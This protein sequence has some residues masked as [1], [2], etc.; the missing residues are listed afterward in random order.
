VLVACLLLAVALAISGFGPPVLSSGAYPPQRLYPEQIEAL[1]HLADPPPISAVSALMV[2][3]DSG[4]TLFAR[5]EHKALPP[6]STAKIMTA[7][8]VLRRGGLADHVTVTNEATAAGGSTMGLQSGETLTVSDLLYGLL[9]PSGNDAAVA[10]AQ[11]VSGSQAGF[12]RL[13]N[14]TAAEMGLAETHFVNP[15]GI[16]DPQ[17][18][19]S[20]ADLLTMVRAALGYPLFAQI[21][22]TQ[23]AEVAGHQLDNTNALLGTYAG[24]DGIKTGT[25]DSAGECLVASVSRRGHRLV[26]IL[27]HSTDRYAD[28]QA[29]LA[30]AAAG[31]QWYP[32]SLPDDSLAWF[33]GQDGRSYRL[34]TMEDTDVFLPIWQRPLTQPVRR[35]NLSVPLTGTLS[36]G[37]L[38][39]T[40]DG[41]VLANVPL[42]VWRER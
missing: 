10:L 35:L 28:A 40:L 5:G 11:H 39:L 37:T 25:T 17:Q 9:L 14:E 20:A 21:V 24:A 4:Q 6:A 42:G 23:H 8:L 38:S 33:R 30:Y 34:R 18:T 16:D 3:L 13:M 32:V 2:D 19:S 15:H 22:A 27:L 41:H 29:L 26:A 36:V 12:V 31:W 7:L 1:S